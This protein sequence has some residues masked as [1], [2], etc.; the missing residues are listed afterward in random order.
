MRHD[1]R[2]VVGR[3]LIDGP[4]PGGPVQ[5]PVVRRQEQGAESGR[6]CRTPYQSSSR[7]CP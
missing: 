7:A 3:Q 4:L 5:G 1:L 2:S 6:A